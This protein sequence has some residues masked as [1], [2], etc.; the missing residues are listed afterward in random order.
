MTTDDRLARQVAIRLS[1]E[2]MQRLDALADSIPIAS[3]NAIARAALR[4]GLAALEAD[5]SQLLS[6]PKKAK[7]RRR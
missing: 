1:E 5:P 2:D 7:A 3:R 6:S 4:I